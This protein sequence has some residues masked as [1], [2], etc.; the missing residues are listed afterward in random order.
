MEEWLAFHASSVSLV[1]TIGAVV[2]AD[3][4]VKVKE[5]FVMPILMVF[6]RDIRDRSILRL[7]EPDELKH[8]MNFHSALPIS[9]SQ[10]SFFDDVNNDDA[11]QPLDLANPRLMPG[12]PLSSGTWDDLSYFSEPEFD[13][14]YRPQHVHKAKV[15]EINHNKSK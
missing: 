9:L 5:S 13:S 14:D 10:L 7:F 6:D 4:V 15:L 3:H 11:D 12:S 8:P 1:E 2:V